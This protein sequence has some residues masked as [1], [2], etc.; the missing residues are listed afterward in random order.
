M[1]DKIIT[2]LLAK[3]KAQESEI[4]RITSYDLKTNLSFPTRDHS[5][6][7]ENVNLNIISDVPTLIG[8]VA[9]LNMYNHFHHEACRTLDVTGQFKW[10]GFTYQDW[11]HDMKHRVE[12]IGLKAKKL[13][14]KVIQDQLNDLMS[15]EMKRKQ[16]LDEIA[17]SLED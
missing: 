9:I 7:R 12:V 6:I 3:A 2:T 10:G 15:P 14:L 1:S 11:I 13:K 17:A 16:Q 5:S 8:Y 4:G